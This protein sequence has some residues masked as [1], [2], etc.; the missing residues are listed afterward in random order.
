MNAQRGPDGR[1]RASAAMLAAM[2]CISSVTP[3]AGTRPMLIANTGLNYRVWLRDG[4]ESRTFGAAPRL[5]PPTIVASCP[6]E[7]NVR[8]FLGGIYGI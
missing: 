7:S 4:L 1:P 8:A 5:V 2:G 6:R 3:T